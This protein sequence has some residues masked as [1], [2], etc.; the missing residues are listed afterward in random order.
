MSLL[1]D[2]NPRQREA[3]LHTEGPLLVLAGAGSGKT[4]VIVTRVAHLILDKGVSPS[5]ILA[6]TFTNKAAGEMR[7]RIGSLLH[8]HGWAGSGLPA[9]STFHSFCLR[10][11]RQ[12]GEPLA[13]IRP[14]FTRYFGV[15][16]AT[17]QLAVVKDAAQ[18]A[19]VGPGVIK[20]RALRSGISKIKNSGLS[21]FESRVGDKL[22]T[23]TLSAVFTCY[24]AELLASNLLDFDDLLLE[25]VS[26]LRHS[27]AVREAVRD[28]YHHLLIDEY[29]DTNH[30]QFDLMRLVTEPRRNVCVVGDED[31]AIYSWRGADI[32][33]ILGFESHFPAAKIIRL[34][35]NY[36]STRS[37]LAAASAVVQRNFQ[38]LG[39]TLW[40]EGPVGD[41]L[42]H[43]RAADAWAEARFVTHSVRELLDSDPDIRVSVL[44]RTNAQSRQLETA[45]HREGIE[46]VL[47]GGVAFFDR[48]EI[49]DLLAYLR[50]AVSPEDGIS[51][52]RILNVPARGIGRSTV[53]RLREHASLHGTS[54]WRALEEAVDGRFV[55]RRARSALSAFRDLMVAMREKAET[56]D[57]ESLVDWALNET[58]Y[59]EMLTSDSSDESIARRENVHELI[60][61][62][63]E[64]DERD[65]TLQEFLDHAALVADTDKIQREVRVLLMTL[66]SAKGLEF[67]V[68]VIAGMDEALLPHW[69][70]KHDASGRLLEEE[71]RLCY[72]GMTRAQ[73][74]LILT[75]A[76]VRWMYGEEA[77]M[78]T[79]PSR[80]LREIPP[81]LINEVWWDSARYE[82]PRAYSGS[83]DDLQASGSPRSQGGPSA[84]AAAGLQTRDSLGAVA[85]F[86][87]QRGVP[88]DVQ[89]AKAPPPSDPG[90]T[91]GRPGAAKPAK[92]K[93]GQ[94]VRG[95]HAQG[96]FARGSR[97]MHRKFGIGVV[98]RR[99]GEGPKAKLSVYFDKY[100]LKK[101]IAGPAKLQ[102]L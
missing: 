89:P 43:Y 35:Q 37:I 11:L 39:K 84:V 70:I 63:Q 92:P 17:D 102:E 75:G 50:A 82:A 101:L 7:D 25:A 62:A 100:G 65:E 4:R 19:G 5:S 46:F 55:S 40:T 69:T 80:F 76:R 52:R 53:G 56:A 78:P 99:E 68:V 8:N 79:R 20:P 45:L 47:V 34:E 74:H 94:A 86:F 58:G 23:Q 81:E 95:L 31:Q 3:V 98:Q 83:L 85:T 1:A 32:G 91:G 54:L 71:R 16:D 41:Q 18:A 2:L 66:H 14:G 30:A 38:R 13:E 61:A 64:A 60:V 67:P 73:R 24:Q 72:V 90:A 33:N 29:Q 27:S 15:C 22:D 21:D 77:L 26:L 57:I 10:L 28:R 59:R 48:A 87:Q 49:R 96:P 97:V 44:Y 93:L 88:L 51:L 42:V 12:H 9:V 6:V 36:R